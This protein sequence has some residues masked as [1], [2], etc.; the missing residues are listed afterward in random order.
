[1]LVGY[2][3]EILP[4]HIRA[5]GLTMMFLMVDIAL[6]FNQYVNPIALKHIGWKVSLLL[7]AIWLDIGKS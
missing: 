5:K 6:F 2:S 7:S 3:A 4:Y 1:M